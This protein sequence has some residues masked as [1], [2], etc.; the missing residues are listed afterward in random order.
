[1]APT[2]KT[3]TVSSNSCSSSSTE[4]ASIDGDILEISSHTWAI[5]GEIAVDGEILMAEFDSYD[6]PRGNVLDQVRRSTAPYE[7]DL[8]AESSAEEFTAP[9][10]AP[11][12]DPTVRAALAR[13]ERR[14]EMPTTSPISRGESRGS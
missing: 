9:A 3:Q 14:V 1:M 6:G 12:S 4:N 11:G 5:H 13:R 8:I 7:R 2:T 10:S